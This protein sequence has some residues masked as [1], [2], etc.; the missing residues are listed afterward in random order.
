MLMKNKKGGVSL[1]IVLLVFLV[2]FLCSASLFIFNTSSRT[3]I[4]ETSNVGIVNEAIFEKNEIEF[5]IRGLLE[6]S[7]KESYYEILTEKEIFEYPSIYTIRGERIAEFEG[8]NRNLNSLFEKNVE[9][10]VSRFLQDK[11]VEIN[12]DGEII[13]AYSSNLSIEKYSKNIN[14][15]YN[16]K[17]SFEFDLKSMGLE[18][19]EKIYQTKELCLGELNSSLIEN[20]FNRELEHFVANVEEEMIHEESIFV[21]SLISKKD[22]FVEK[23]F[24]KVE[25]KFIPVAVEQKFVI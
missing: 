4:D 20:C 9:E 10:K 24:R 22:F 23:D 6:T 19:F 16:P 3:V 14:V 11:N 21:V 8:L 2:L 5:F 18:E 25:L 7:V 13:N 12:F 15:S 17:I 1:S